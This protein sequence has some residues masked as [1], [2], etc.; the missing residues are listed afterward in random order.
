MLSSVAIVRRCASN[1][2][3]ATF[4]PHKS[5]SLPDIITTQLAMIDFVHLKEFVV[6]AD[7]FVRSL[8]NREMLLFRDPQAK[9]FHFACMAVFFFFFLLDFKNVLVGC[10]VVFRRFF[11]LVSNANSLRSLCY[12]I[13]SIVPATN[14]VP[15]SVVCDV[16]NGCTW[17]R[18]RSRQFSNCNPTAR[19]RSLGRRKHNVVCAA[20]GERNVAVGAVARCVSIA[21]RDLCRRKRGKPFDCARSSCDESVNCHHRGSGFCC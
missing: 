9:T 14:F 18:V 10:N 21:V 19:H 4:R 6:Q 15:R 20:S 3:L 1:A 2:K 13:E 8:A 11:L 5:Y 17:N 7:G 12:C 16:S